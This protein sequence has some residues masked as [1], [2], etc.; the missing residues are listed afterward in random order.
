VI[1]HRCSVSNVAAENIAGMA[2]SGVCERLTAYIAAGLAFASAVTTAYWLLGGTALLDTVGGYAEHLARSRSVGALVVG[3]LV[4]VVKLA[5]APL[6]LAVAHPPAGRRP[7]RLLL[8]VAAFGGLVLIAYGG[9]LVAVGALVL[10]DVIHPDGP[11]NR[12]VLT[13]HVTVWDLWFLLWG[14]ALALATWRF[15]RTTRTR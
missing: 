12:R 3:A 9:L 10:A 7:R 1:G 4:I 8:I 13:W 2:G 5:G 15:S 6:A 11:V 14:L